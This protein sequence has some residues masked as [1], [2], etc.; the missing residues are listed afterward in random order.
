MQPEDYI[1]GPINI[2]FSF[3]SQSIGASREAV[4]RVRPAV[5]GLSPG[6]A[7]G[8]NQLGFPGGTAAE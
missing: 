7:D 2:S 8:A 1:R 6:G 3:S 5:P 4:L